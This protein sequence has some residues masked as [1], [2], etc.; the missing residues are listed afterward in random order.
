VE[1]TFELVSNKGLTAGLDTRNN[2]LKL[3]LRMDL[4]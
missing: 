3:T 1:Y 2:Y 4:K